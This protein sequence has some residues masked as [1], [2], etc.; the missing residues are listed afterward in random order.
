MTRNAPTRV[1]EL[2]AAWLLLVVLAFIVLHAPLSVYVGSNWPALEL[3]VK[4]WKELLMSL[5]AVLLAVEVS[6]QHAWQLFTRDKLF[7][8]VVGYAA[9]HFVSL[10]LRPTDAL[11][12]VAG[13]AIDLR[14][15]LYFALIYAFLRLYPGYVR[16]FL[17]VAAMGAC[18]VVGFAALQL[19]LPPDAL[20]VFGY[21]DTTIQPYLTVDENHDY[22]RH[23]STLRGPNPLGAY[24]LMVLVAVVAA[25]MHY[26]RRLTDARRKLLHAGLAIGGGIAVWISYSRSAVIGLLIALALIVGVKR[27]VRAT[28]KSIMVAV[29]VLT[30]LGAMW[31]IVQ[32]TS[33]VHNVVLHDNPSTGA[34]VDSNT[35]HAVS[36]ADGLQSALIQ[37]LGT[38][39]GSTGSAS[40]FGDAHTIIE[41]QYLMVA[42]ETGWAGLALFVVIFVSV[43]LRLWKLRSDWMALAVWASGIGLATIGLLLPVW[44]DDTVSIVWWGLAAVILAKGAAYGTTSNKKAA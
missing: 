9:L 6:R 41:N 24:A 14:Y 38:G 5:A 34:S 37:P 33:F 12:A 13:I 26:G 29:I 22:I 23:N 42:H 39:V 43:L 15:I 11:V 4:A 16:S 35:G 3:V 36:L 17:K 30:A 19:V 28:K 1:L 27:K 44:V 20:R 21:S 7:W 32:G 2:S 18:I 31:Y 40:L 25:G 8:C 10:L